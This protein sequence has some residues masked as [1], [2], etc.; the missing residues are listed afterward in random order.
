M[1]E[2]GS[3][4]NS[5][6]HSENGLQQPLE[7]ENAPTVSSV[8]DVRPDDI[9]C[10]LTWKKTHESQH[11]RILGLKPK[12][13][14]AMLSSSKM[15]GGK[16]YPPELPGESS[17]YVVEFDGL[18]DPTHPQNWSMSTKSV[19]PHSQQEFDNSEKKND[20]SSNCD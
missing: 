8:P 2:N 19:L 17:E 4:S 10:V 15:G 7:I 20:D 5:K 6:T 13:E 11:S 16:P 1:D 12:D 3:L 14:Q 9:E 18:D